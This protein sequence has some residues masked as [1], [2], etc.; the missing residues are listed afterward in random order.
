MVDDFKQ[1]FAKWSRLGINSS[2]DLALNWLRIAKLGNCLR[3][4]TS[5]CDVL[6]AVRPTPGGLRATGIIIWL[7]RYKP[8]RKPKHVTQSLLRT[9]PV[10]VLLASCSRYAYEPLKGDYVKFTAVAPDYP[11]FAP[12]LGT[13]YVEPKNRPV[14]PYRAYDR[15]GRLTA[16]I[17]MIPV[18]M[19]DDQLKFVSNETAPAVD[20]WQIHYVRT[21]HGLTG[22]HYHITLWHISAEESAA[23]K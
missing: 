10:I 1:V 2:R 23:I 9:L 17:Y 15:G 6:R 12:G 3:I 4:A 18:E 19:L 7:R 16:T 11:A 21:M 13:V 22:P 8:A 20:H 5:C 14:G